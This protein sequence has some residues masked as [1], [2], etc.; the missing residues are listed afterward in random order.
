M[1]CMKSLNPLPI[2]VEALLKEVALKGDEIAN[3]FL[4]EANKIKNERKDL[5]KERHEKVSEADKNDIEK[6]NKLLLEYN[7]K[8]IENEKELILNEVDKMHS[9]YEMGLELAEKLKKITVDQLK[10]KLN[11]TP[12]IGRAALNSQINEVNKYTP[13]EF[14]NSKFGKPLKNALDKQGL[15]EEYL[16]ELIQVLEEERKMRRASERNEFGISNNEFPPEDELNFTV[17]DLFEAIFDEYKGEFKSEIKK[18]I[19]DKVL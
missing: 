10:K 5:L 14:L 17:K 2:E 3:T 9:I 12:E 18:K 16:N 4:I 7:K 13:K 15:R 19:L 6:L 1:G 8:E 11:D